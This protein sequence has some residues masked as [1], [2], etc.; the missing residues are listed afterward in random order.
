MGAEIE[1]SRGKVDELLTMMNNAKNAGEKLENTFATL[2]TA[3]EGNFSGEATE[4]IVQL[5]DKEIEKI[6]Q[7]KEN[8]QTT[9]ENTETIASGI[10][11]QD[12][13]LSIL[14]IPQQI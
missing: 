12:Q 3:V 8:W 11:R 1:H 7:E 9:Y 5:L 6:R 2:L 14:P 4:S 10:E 13:E